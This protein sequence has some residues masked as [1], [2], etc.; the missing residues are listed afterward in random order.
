M[1]R[2]SIAHPTSQRESTPGEIL[3]TPFPTDRTL[4]KSLRFRTR[5]HFQRVQ[6][7]GK[8]FHSRHLI[9][10]LALNADHPTR[11]GITVSKK[12]GKAHQR[13]YLK[14][15]IREAFRHSVLRRS[16]GFDI[17]LIAKKDQPSPKLSELIIELD[18]LAQNARKLSAA[19]RQTK[20][21]K[22]HRNRRSHQRSKSKKNHTL[23]RGMTQNSRQRHEPQ[24]CSQQPEKPK[25]HPSTSRS[26]EGDTR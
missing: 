19:S 11:C 13:S 12:V 8:R 21:N 14:R 1:S 6:Q 26:G 5:G 16:L 18:H 10:Y 7:T 23:Q 24:E 3:N 17:S 20:H 9:A 4:P 15:L 22:H 2:E 25:K